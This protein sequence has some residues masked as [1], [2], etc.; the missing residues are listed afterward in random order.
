MLLVAPVAEPVGTPLAFAFEASLT[1][2]FL[3]AGV[4]TVE[5]QASCIELCEIPLTDRTEL[6]DSLLLTSS[7]KLGQEQLIS[8]N[9]ILRCTLYDQHG[10]ALMEVVSFSGRQSKVNHRASPALR[11]L[12][13]GPAAVC[14]ACCASPRRKR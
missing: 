10:E 2:G 3:F 8:N 5:G 7:S 4:A 11:V 13:N 12:R 14:E 1:V 6:L 9:N